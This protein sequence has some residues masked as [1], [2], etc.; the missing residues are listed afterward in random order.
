ML[1]GTKIDLREQYKSEL[2]EEKR[3][4]N[5]F[6]LDYQNYYNINFKYD[7]KYLNKEWKKSLNEIIKNAKTEHVKYLE[8]YLLYKCPKPEITY[9]DGEKLAKLI[10]AEKYLECSAKTRE[11]IK[12]IFD[13]CI[14][15]VLYPREKEK[16]KY[17][18]I[19]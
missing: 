8:R 5:N 11:G 13:E 16:N 1:V 3:R 6:Y 18:I 15:S 10:N 7:D 4:N 2:I 14:L 19:N 9:Q 12:D 17:C